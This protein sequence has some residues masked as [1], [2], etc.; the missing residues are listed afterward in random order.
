[1][2]WACIVVRVFA[3]PLSNVFQKLLTRRGVSPLMVVGVTH[4]VL[5]VAGLPL[6]PVYLPPQASA[7]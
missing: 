1:M 7:F 2:L 3:N 4:G 5:A 6:L